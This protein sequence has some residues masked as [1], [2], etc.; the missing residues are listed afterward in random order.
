MSVAGE[1]Q[2]E[3]G[4]FS[5]PKQEPHCDNL[6]L[7]C[8]YGY[9]EQEQALFLKAVDSQSHSAKLIKITQRASCN[10]KAG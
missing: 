5:G 8:N 9:S 10:T 7:E 4:K 6:G 3:S 2:D 1:H